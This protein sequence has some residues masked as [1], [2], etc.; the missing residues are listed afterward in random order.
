MSPQDD[1]VT[2]TI[3]TTAQAHV[4]SREVWSPEEGELEDVE[5]DTVKV[6][7]DPNDSE[8]SVKPSIKVSLVGDSSSTSEVKEQSK[9][10]DQTRL[11]HEVTIC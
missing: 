11:V 1:H 7:V 4:T 8:L 5:E 9:E 2:A 3:T 10:S 6:N